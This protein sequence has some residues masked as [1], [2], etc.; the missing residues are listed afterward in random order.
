MYLNKIRSSIKY[1]F[2]MCVL[3][4]CIFYNINGTNAQVIVGKETSLNIKDS[5]LFHTDIEKHTVSL[6]IAKE[7]TVYNLEELS[8][9]K[10]VIPSR[11]ILRASPKTSLVK[12]VEK[13]KKGKTCRVV[14]RKDIKL[15]IRASKDENQSLISGSYTGKIAAIT[16]N[17]YKAKGAILF[18]GYRKLLI[19][20]K[21]LITKY[22]VKTK[23]I[24]GFILSG[25]HA[26][27]PPP[28][29]YIV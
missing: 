1:A 21:K 14:L 3:L 24:E 4:C 10:V 22:D 15:K 23:L 17:I 29:K 12:S 19:F 11:K 13:A 2:G 16:T 9:K 7:T 5:I 27:P 20:S 8:N 6:Y 28:Y 26:R 18:S 25:K